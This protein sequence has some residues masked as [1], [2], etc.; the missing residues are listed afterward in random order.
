MKLPGQCSPFSWPPW[1]RVFGIKFGLGIEEHP[2]SELYQT[3]EKRIPWRLGCN[4]P[5]FPWPPGPPFF[6]IKLGSATKDHPA[7][8]LNQTPR[9]LT[10]GPLGDQSTLGP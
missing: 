9:K 8:N 10:P 3:S 4:A 7:T 1:R 6:E 2:A 5:P